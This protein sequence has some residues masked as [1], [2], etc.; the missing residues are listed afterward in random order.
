MEMKPKEFYFS[1]RNSSSKLITKVSLKFEISGL[2][3]KLYIP[4][5]KISHGFLSEKLLCGVFLPEF[6][7]ITH[8]V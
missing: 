8:V 7:Q 2:M 6:G 3:K 5:S 4:K 1:L